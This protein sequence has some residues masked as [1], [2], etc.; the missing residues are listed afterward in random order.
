MTKKR[1][2]L[3][4]QLIDKAKSIFLENGWLFENQPKFERFCETLA[5]L[6][7]EQRELYF[8]LTRRF[9]VY[10]DISSYRNGI[11]NVFSK[12]ETKDFL[13]IYIY[14]LL[15]EE[16]LNKNKSSN[17]VHYQF[18]DARFELPNDVDNKLV[19]LDRPGEGLPK[20][21]NSNENLKI[22]LV[23]DFIGTGE[24][25]LGAV[26]YL[27]EKKNV[28]KNK[29]TILSLVAQ[30]KG[31]DA[32]EAEDIAV[33]SNMVRN[34]GISDNYTEETKSKYLIIMEKVEKLINVSEGYRFGYGRSEA[35]VKVVRTPNNTFPIYWMVNRNPPFKG[36]FPRKK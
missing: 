9:L 6:T 3:S 2:A 26:K 35:L 7:N 17:F 16:D 19:F 5:I 36:M 18:R 28:S 10:E 27:C 20:D 21:V 12:V 30:Q 29:I 25:A 22:I 11:L 34:K 31:I 32:I 8:E 14:P 1:K 13:K 33:Y 24:T 4:P 23:D 15:S